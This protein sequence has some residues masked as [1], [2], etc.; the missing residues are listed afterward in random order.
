V[1]VHDAQK[2]VAEGVSFTW[3]YLTCLFWDLL[4]LWLFGELSEI[5][6]RLLLTIFILFESKFLKIV[7]QLFRKVEIFAGFLK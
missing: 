6:G 3:K 5:F 7:I 4:E 2:F 1:G